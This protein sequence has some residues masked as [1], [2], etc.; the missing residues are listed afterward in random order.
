MFVGRNRELAS[1]EALYREHNFQC[2]V[3]W[4]RRRVGKTT[5][6]NE[7]TQ[8]KRTIFFTGVDSTEKINLELF[9]LAIADCENI[10][11]DEAIIYDNFQKAFN[12]INRLAQK[13]Q[14]ILVIDE[15]PYLAKSYPA[16]SSLLQQTI[17]IKFKNSN[18]FI[19]LCGSS[20]SFMENQ[21]LGYQSPLYGRRTA[22]YKIEPFNFYEACNYYQNFTK[23]DLAIAF[24][25]TGGIPLY[26]SFLNDKLTIK[27]N[28]C[29]NFLKSNGFLYEEPVNLMNQELRTPAVYNAIISAIAHGS[30]KNSEIANAVGLENSAASNYLEKLMGLALVQKVNPIGNP[31][32]R[33]TIYELKDTMFDFWYRFIPINKAQIERNRDDLAWQYVDKN[34]NGYM[35]HVFEKI[36][37]DYLWENIDSLPFVFSNIGKWWGP[38]P[39]TRKEEEIDILAVAGNQALVAECKWRNAKTDTNVLNTLIDRAN[40]LPYK[41]KYLYVFSKSGFT[42]QAIQFAKRNNIELIAYNDMF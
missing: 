30:S 35:G 2:A 29:Q 7:F 27:E 39:Q 36:C 33:K 11:E 25:I 15:Y 17:D 21:V 32:T 40:L 42:D 10:A 28:I 31:S 19:I 9:S 38:N 3:I 22:Q 8:N 16:I 20:M 26:M 14:I 24:G 13:E 34:L 1:L 41:E 37:V 12:A 5:L 18:L 4:G 6:I 23:E